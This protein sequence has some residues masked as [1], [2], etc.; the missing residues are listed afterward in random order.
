VTTQKGV[1]MTTLSA[2]IQNSF[3]NVLKTYED[4]STMLQDADAF[5][6][7]AGYQCLHGNTIGTASSKHISS[8]RWWVY[9]Y[10]TRY[11]TNEEKPAEIK[12]IGVL[13]IDPN[14]SAAVPVILIGTFKSTGNPRIDSKYHYTYLSDA[15]FKTNEERQYNIEYKVEA[16]DYAESGTVKGFAIDEVGDIETLNEKLI[17]PLLAMDG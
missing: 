11:Y 1:I 15:W 5:M 2:N 16:L 4:I 17:Q 3:S 8:P 6:E 9:P 12:A 7:M 13:L 14:Q 10:V